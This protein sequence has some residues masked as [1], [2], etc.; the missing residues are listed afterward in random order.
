MCI[1]LYLGILSSYV[2]EHIP[3]PCCHHSITDCLMFIFCANI[4]VFQ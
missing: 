4:G 2:T 1:D 3:N